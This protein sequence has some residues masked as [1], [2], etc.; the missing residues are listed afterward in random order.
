MKELLDKKGKLMI[1]GEAVND[2]NGNDCS[3]LFGEIIR[4]AL[5][6]DVADI[7]KLGISVNLV[8]DGTFLQDGSV[9]MS[10]Y[11]S[12]KDKNNT[13]F[14][15]KIGNDEFSG[16]YE[17]VF[18]IKTNPNGTI[19]KMVCGNFK[20]LKKNDETILEIKTPADILLTIEKGKTV[21]TLKG[22]NNEIIR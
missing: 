3:A 14:K 21:I 16:D 18:A 13:A 17:G 15:I 20:S 22:E 8:L 19:E 12:V 1:K 6:F 7:S 2:F 11:R 5:P 10:N 4:Q 9:V